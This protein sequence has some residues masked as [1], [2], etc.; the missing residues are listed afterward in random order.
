MEFIESRVY[1]AVNADKLGPGD[2]VICADTLDNLKRA[3]HDDLVYILDRVRGP[4][5]PYRFSVVKESKYDYSEY[6]YAYLVCPARNVK[7]YYAWAEGKP[8]EVSLNDKDFIMS[9]VEPEWLAYSYRPKQAY[10]PFKNCDELIDYYKR[11]H[12]YKDNEDIMPSI[13]VKEK[14]KENPSKYLITGFDLDKVTIAAVVFKLY[15]LF[16]HFVFFDDTPCGV[17]A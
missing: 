2:L 5:V 15:D 11:M 7:A 12:C 8:I 16:E 13:W 3:V 9:I 4:D 6:E 14:G 10:R 1:S 17:P